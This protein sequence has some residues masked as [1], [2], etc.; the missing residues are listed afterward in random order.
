MKAAGFAPEVEEMPSVA[1]VKDRSH[2]PDNL[3][4]CHTALVSG[5]VVEGHVP[6]DAVKRLLR[7]KPKVAGIAV[8][9]MPA[10]SPGMEQG[11]RKDA[12]E[13][14]AFTA[15]GKTSTYEKR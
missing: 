9:G 12:Y 7:E 11:D 2:V 6:A 4:S 1:P 14:V 3:R 13:V 5:Y 15:D 10:G 8:A